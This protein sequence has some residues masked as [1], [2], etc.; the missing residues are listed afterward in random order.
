[1]KDKRKK[2]QKTQK[3][4]QQQQEEDENKRRLVIYIGPPKTASTTLQ[5]FLAKYASP[6]PKKHKKEAIEA[7]KDWSYPLFFG[8]ADGLVYYIKP[9]EKHTKKTKKTPQYIT[10][11]RNEFGRQPRSKNLVVASEYLVYY[12]IR[13]KGHVFHMFSTWTNISRPEVV[14]HSRTPRTSQL[15]SLWKQVSQRKHIKDFYDW[16]FPRF[17]CSEAP[18]KSVV[19]ALDILMN[20]IGLA[21]TLIHKYGLPTYYVDMEGIAEQELDVCHVF[22][23]SILNVNCTDGDNKWVNGIKPKKIRGKNK[24]DG[25]PSISDDQFDQMENLFR[26]RDCAYGDELSHHPLFRPV[27]LRPEAWP[28]QCSNVEA[29]PSY[30]HNASLL[31]EDLRSI[32]N[33]SGYEVGG[34]MWENQAATGAGF[35][36]TDE[37]AE[38]LLLQ[39]YDSQ[40]SCTMLVGRSNLQT[41]DRQTRTS[42]KVV[43]SP[44]KRRV[45]G[46]SCESHNLTSLRMTVIIFYKTSLQSEEADVE[47]GGCSMKLT[48][49]SMT[50]IAK[51]AVER[52]GSAILC[53]YYVAPKVTT[54]PYLRI[55]AMMGYPSVA[56]PYIDA[57]PS[58]AD[59]NSLLN[60]FLHSA[61]G[62][63]G[64]GEATNVSLFL[65]GLPSLV[66]FHTSLDNV[67]VAGLTLDSS[68][69]R[70]QSPM[71]GSFTAY[72]NVTL[73][74]KAR[75]AK[76]QELFLY[77]TNLLF[78]RSLPQRE[79]YNEAENLVQEISKYAATAKVITS[80]QWTDLL[81]R[82]RNDVVKN[83][84]VADLLP[85][86]EYE[87]YM[88]A[89][90]GLA[91]SKLIPRTNNWIEEQGACLDAIQ[92]DS[93]RDGIGR[94][95]F[96]TRFLQKGSVVM[97]TPII[98]VHQNS[99]GIKNNAHNNSQQLLLNY[100]LGHRRSTTLFCPTT[101]AALMNHDGVSP[102]VKLR[103][104]EPA[105][106][107]HGSLEDYWNASTSRNNMLTLE[108]IAIRDIQ[109][110]E[111]LLLGYGEEWEEAYET[112]LNQGVSDAT[113]LPELSAEV[114]N[115]VANDFW[116]LS[117]HV[118]SHLRAECMIHPQLSILEDKGQW[119]DFSSN[120]MVHKENWPSG[121][122]L[123]Y[124]Q[125][126]MAGWNPCE[127]VSKQP[128]GKMFDVRVFPQD[129]AAKG[130]TRR[131]RGVPRD[132]IRFVN[133]PYHSDQ[134]LPWAFRH[135][136]SIPDEIFPLRWRDDYKAADHWKLG[137]VEERNLQSSDEIQRLQEE[138]ETTLRQA[139]CGV[140]MAT[141]N[142]P[143]AGFGTYAAVDIP[144][145]N[146]LVGSSIPEVPLNKQRDPSWPGTEYVWQSHGLP[147]N[148]ECP[149]VLRGLFG[150][151]ANS[152]TGITN[153]I[154]PPRYDPVY[155]PIVDRRF[156]P[157]A[158]AFTP[159]FDNHFLSAYPVKAGEELFVTYGEHWYVQLKVSLDC[160]LCVI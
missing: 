23:C 74:A 13:H 38:A 55:T 85:L 93:S 154:S 126:D 125:D 32:L 143:N 148:L 139:K 7:F 25:D 98:P 4:K 129:L 133:A 158:G 118:P 71:A 64:F 6:E 140:Y 21:D 89:K 40:V 14:V 10:H 108:Y 145:Q 135:Y 107:L 141:S 22:A 144:A 149:E 36:M 2:T 12:D 33:C 124:A 54:T 127:V 50:S 109:E 146:I 88:A 75:I 26:Q 43:A 97:T 101:S 130:M 5:T 3:A 34:D 116:I 62:I 100:C 61:D 106:L 115:N 9:S 76:G 138:Y 66:Q 29:A 150:A 95:G 15:I 35:F 58:D 122:R 128:D 142:I 37:E 156:D 82:M 147:E 19:Q 51:K 160:P 72:H 104:K 8:R 132:R 49:C 123:I 92:Q 69:Y 1:M 131:F 96:S 153:M 110:G 24:K 136:I 18:K 87:L 47:R 111:E 56:I 17:M 99:F 52:V 41:V 45:M 42:E 113:I 30:R 28:N 120:P 105:T 102:N 151:I 73:V 31:L 81:F 48:A 59:L 114:Y 39:S 80:A 103:W 44:A 53:F 137:L 65:P 78:Q 67:V 157:G 117:E 70:N 63:G 91:R 60:Q 86:S 84:K 152:H 159:Y 119:E 112:H 79:A 121:Q 57:E 77:P 46:K 68:M 90:H 134:H 83:T 155:D 27:Y 16:S 20:P 11:V 94:G